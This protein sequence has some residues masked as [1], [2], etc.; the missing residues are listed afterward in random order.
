MCG[1]IIFVNRLAEINFSYW[2]FVN[3]GFDSKLEYG[4]ILTD[5]N[6]GI[7][8]DRFLGLDSNAFGVV[9]SFDYLCV[10]GREILF[11]VMCYDMSDVLRYECSVM[12]YIYECSV[13]I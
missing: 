13:T 8:L 12:C 1:I 5:E 7:G 3:N 6:V 10:L 4:A 2:G 9:A 11:C